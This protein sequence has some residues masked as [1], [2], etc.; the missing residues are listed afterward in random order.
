MENPSAEARASFST[1]LSHKYNSAVVNEYF[2]DLFSKVANVQFEVDAG[3]TSTNVTRLERMIRNADA[4]IGIY[5]FEPVDLADPSPQQLLEASQYF[6]LELDLATRARK[7]GLIFTD[8]RYGNVLSTPASMARESFD[9]KEIVSAGAKPSSDKFKL[10]FVD[11]RDRIAANKSFRLAERAFEKVTSQVGILVPHGGD[12]SAYRRDHIELI[13][14]EIS[15]RYKPVVMDWPPVLTPEWMGQVREFDWMVLDIGAESMASGI[16][17]YLHGAFVPSMRLLYDADPSQPQPPDSSLYAGV[18]VGY[19]KDTIRWSNLDT[20]TVEIRN[21]LK[22]LN[23]GTRRLSTLNEAV[24]YFLEATRRKEP[25]FVSYSGVDEDLSAELRMALRKRFQQVFDYRD[26]KSI[27]PGQPWIS[28]IF[29]Q[30]NRSAIGIP[31]LSSNYVA[32]GNCLHELRDIVALADQG[33][34]SMVPVKL[35]R[36]DDFK[37]PPEIRSTQYARLWE[38]GSAEKLVDWIVDNLPQTAST[39][40]TP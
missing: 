17:G 39:P 24:D 40:G 32:S 10:H 16:V 19:K 25:I 18:T 36:G 11:L 28:A 38:Y 22:S 31:L 21:R 1:F 20:L 27:A 8:S 9:I 14:T 34:L 6:R 26:G 29:D 15:G 23:F 33:K 5:P 2:F 35:R 30:I 12:S 4:F 37:N 13:R 3:K 7:P